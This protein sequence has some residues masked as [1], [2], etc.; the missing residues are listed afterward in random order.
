MSAKPPYHE[1]EGS[2]INTWLYMIYEIHE[3]FTACIYS[4]LLITRTL[5]PKNVTVLG[6]FICESWNT[7]YL[8]EDKFSSLET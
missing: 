4:Q 5:V 7:H 6:Y 1:T 2:R 3:S 8:C